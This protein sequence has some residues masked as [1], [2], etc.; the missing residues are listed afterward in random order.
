MKVYLLKMSYDGSE[1]FG[2]QRQKGLVTI[3]GELEK[4]LS[5]ILQE[6]ISVVASGRT[7][8]GVHAI[9]Q[10]AHF[11]TKKEI[12]DEESEPGFAILHNE[13]GF[14]VLPGNI[15]FGCRCSGN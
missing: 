6:E 7:D 1:F 8:A 9:A 11:D 12:K 13:G 3:Q 2:F 14:D 15:E 5:T 4:V 10:V